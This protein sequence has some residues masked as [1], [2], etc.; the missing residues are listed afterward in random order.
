MKALA[1]TQAA[2]E[3]I[4]VPG[5]RA[6]PSERVIGQRT[7]RFVEIRS[8]LVRICSSQGDIQM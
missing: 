5:G 8:I 7:L 2:R 3:A 1:L 4:E 6:V